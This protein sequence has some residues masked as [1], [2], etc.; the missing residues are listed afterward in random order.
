MKCLYIYYMKASL[1]YQGEVHFLD[2]SA[3]GSQQELTN[4]AS[5]LFSLP[6]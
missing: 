5:K 3:V 6:P 1:D 4:I 2:L